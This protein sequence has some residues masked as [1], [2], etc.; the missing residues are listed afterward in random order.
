MRSP[1]DLVAEA[2]SDAPLLKKLRRKLIR[3]AVL[4]G[5]FCI[6]A[7]IIT[8]VNLFALIRVFWQPA[9]VLASPLYLLFAA[10]SLL[11]TLNFARSC[12]RLLQLRASSLGS[13]DEDLQQTDGGLEI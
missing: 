12:R 8:L 10:V 11:A 7:G 4:L 2:H 5:A 9:Q 6:A 3:R 1:L 13:G